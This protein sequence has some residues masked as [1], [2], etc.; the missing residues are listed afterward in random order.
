MK[1]YFLITLVVFCLIQFSCTF[2]QIKLKETY[3]LN[4][5]EKKIINDF[6][7]FELTSELYK[8]QKKESV[9]IIRDAISKKQ[10]IEDYEAILINYKNSV[11][12]SIQIG[13]L[14]KHLENEP[15]YYWKKTDFNNIKTDLKS[16]DDFKKFIN[17]E[18]Y[19]YSHGKSVFYLSIPYF[20]TKNKVLLSYISGNS[21][22]GF[23][24]INSSI[25]MMVKNNDGKW[26][27][28]EYLGSK[29]Y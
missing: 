29:Y 11:F 10:V 12:D 18:E 2:S 23:N 14:K 24:L 13:E 22:L 4:N 26:I 20:I 27:L 21:E 6:L 25:V 5:V 15:L 7:E 28:T 16:R 19:L 17:N 8:Y 3:R 9:I 1:K